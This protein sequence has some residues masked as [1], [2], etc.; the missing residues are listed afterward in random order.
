MDMDSLVSF[1]QK[2][3]NQT[4]SDHSITLAEGARSR[5]MRLFW[6]QL[7][8]LILVIGIIALR[9]VCKIFVVKKTSLDDWL[10]F[11]AAV[12]LFLHPSSGNVSHANFCSGYV[13]AVWHHGTAWRCCRRNR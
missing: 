6:V 2:A 4:D 5:G 12:R 7:A 11:L 1:L 10:M 13:Y 9:V 8:F 3:E